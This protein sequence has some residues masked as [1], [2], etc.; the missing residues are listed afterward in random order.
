MPE[1]RQ[2][3]ISRIFFVSD[4][5]F[6]HVNI[7]KRCA[8][9]FEEVS[10][11]N[12]AMRINW[13]SVVQP[14]DT[15]YFVGDMTPGKG[16]RPASYWLGQLN[17]QI[18]FVRGN[19][20]IGVPGSVESATFTHQGIKFHVVHNPE[21]RPA[22]LDG[23]TWMIHGHMHNK[24]M[25]TYPFFNPRSRTINVSVELTGYKPMLMDTLVSLIRRGVER[26]PT[27]AEIPAQYAV[28]KNGLVSASPASRTGML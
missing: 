4:T 3:G 18:T 11:M 9:P 5:H 2:V 20:D 6:D 27:A 24:D 19:R 14:W 7:M 22:G 28:I 12:S 15:V 8:R 21:H 25:E 26:V 1:I 17:G 16:F 10:Q 23:N 13:N